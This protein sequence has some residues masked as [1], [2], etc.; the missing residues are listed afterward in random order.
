[1][2]SATCLR[3]HGSPADHVGRVGFFFFFRSGSPANFGGWVL[4]FRAF[5]FSGRRH[6]DWHNRRGL[7]ACVTGWR[8][9]GGYVIVDAGFAEIAF[10]SSKTVMRAINDLLLQIVTRAESRSE[11]SAESRFGELSDIPKCCRTLGWCD[12]VGNLLY[13]EQRHCP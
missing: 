3:G 13:A 1:M 10:L 7:A 9:C 8:G 2:R 6:L 4:L 5:G 11:F 12:K